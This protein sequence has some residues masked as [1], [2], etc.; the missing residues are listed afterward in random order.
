MVPAGL[1]SIITALG[2]VLCEFPDVFSTSK[3]DFGS[4]FLLPFKISI[5]PDTVPGTFHP[6][7]ANPILTQTVDDVLDRYMA[8]GVIHHSTSPCSIPMVAISKKHGSVRITVNYRKINAT[9]SLAQ[10]TIPC[11]DEVLDSLGKGHLFS[12]FDLVSSFHQI[13][14]DKDTIPLTTFCT[15]T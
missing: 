10:L 7:R 12:V 3:T 11:I 6:Y 15:P 14:I 4:C 2:D 13:T 1:P 8:A 5:T 9:S